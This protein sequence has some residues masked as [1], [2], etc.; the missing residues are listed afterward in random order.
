MIKM[1]NYMFWAKRMKSL[2]FGCKR[3]AVVSEKLCTGVR[4]PRLEPRSS[5]AQRIHTVMFITQTS[6]CAI[7]VGIDSGLVTHWYL[8]WVLV[9]R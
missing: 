6:G 1:I 4:D 8:H 9:S 7:G 3:P 5:V 2:E